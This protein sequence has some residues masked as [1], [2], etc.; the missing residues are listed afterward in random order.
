MD[1][2]M[3]EKLPRLSLDEIHQHEGAKVVLFEAG[4]AHVG[5]ITRI[6][7]A[8][9]GNT[10]LGFK[11]AVRYQRNGRVVREGRVPIWQYRP[12]YGKNK[13]FAV[14]EVKEGGQK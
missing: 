8:T 12:G 13:G 1:Y 9:R 5:T 3:L 4:N 14:L 7:A 6:P 11:K 2:Q 10:T